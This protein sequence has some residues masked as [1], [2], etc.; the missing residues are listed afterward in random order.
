MVDEASFFAMSAGK[1][2]IIDLAE[3][4]PSKRIKGI[5]DKSFLGN[6][7]QSKTRGELYV[8]ETFHK[9]GTR[10]AKEDVLSVYDKTTLTIKKEIEW[11][12]ANRLQSLPERYAISLSNDERFL[13]SA[14]FDPAASFTVVDLETH[15]IRG[16]IGT[17]GCVL[18]YP[19]G[20]R[21]I[22]SICSNGAMLTT[23]ID[24]N[25]Q[26]ASQVRSDP[27]FD[28]DKT[29]I[30]EHPVYI[31]GIAYFWS[32]EGILHSFDMLGDQAEYLGQWD[33]RSEKDREANWRPSGLVLNDMDDAGNI[34]TIFQPDGK[35]GTQ[36]HGGSKVRVYDPVNKKL[37]REIDTPRWA[38]SIAVTRGESPLLVVTNGELSLDVFNAL[39]GSYIQTIADFG[40][41]TPL[42][43]HKS[44]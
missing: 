36:T 28:T 40:N 32:F 12:K 25:G 27:F 19:V 44:Y 43:L 10:G 6:F 14:N 5:V 30:F 31:N 37:V 24:E 9:R 33:T 16:E 29:P 42:S 23:L 21:A 39:D 8:M 22:A 26:M 41:T 17:P 3:T 38:I 34:Y 20:E 13:Y 4:K 18:T 11:P 7:G 35:E 1:V 2:I 15:E